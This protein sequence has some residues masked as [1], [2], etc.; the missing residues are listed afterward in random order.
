MVAGGP[1]TSVELADRTST[2]ERYVREWL[3]QQTLAEILEVEDENLPALQRRYRLPPRRAEVLT[4]SESA[5]YLPPI[6]HMLVSLVKPLPTVLEAYRHGGG[7]PFDA[8]GT[9]LREGVAAATS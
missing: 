3:E 2:Q 6:T 8:Y 5:S 1:S 4:D 9:D 7:V